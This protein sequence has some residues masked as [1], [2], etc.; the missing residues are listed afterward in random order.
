MLFYCSP[1]LDTIKMK[2]LYV[3]Q[4]RCLL[5]LQLEVT[6]LAPLE[7]RKASGGKSMEYH[8]LPTPMIP[9]MYQS[10]LA[11]TTLIIKPLP[12]KMA[13]ATLTLILDASTK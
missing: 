13:A 12:V 4:M 2:T 10:A 11:L 3:K 6:E 1:P 7:R 5:V 8:S 9:T